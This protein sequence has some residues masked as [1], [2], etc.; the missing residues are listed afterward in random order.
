VADEHH[1]CGES[2]PLAKT[3]RDRYLSVY[4]NYLQPAFGELCLRDITQL[5]VQRY[6]SGRL[7]AI[8]GIQRQG[9]RCFVE[10]PGICGSLRFVSKES[11]GR[12]AVASTEVG[13]A[14]QA[15]RY[16]AAVF[17]I[18]GPDCG[19]LCDDALHSGVHGAS[20][21]RGHRADPRTHVAHKTRLTSPQV[22][23]KASSAPKQLLIEANQCPF[24]GIC[25]RGS[26][27]AS[28]DM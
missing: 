18:G 9:A 5:T 24:P 25:F 8:A 19:I 16:S 13:E 4:K 3:T 1:L 2:F 23:E 11:G 21:I 15:L 28:K 27:V 14:D 20:A 12:G 10:H 17:D 7:E 22:Q 6:I 26:R